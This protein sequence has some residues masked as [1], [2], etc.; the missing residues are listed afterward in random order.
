MITFVIFEV[1]PLST[2]SIKVL[3]LL[4]L[5]LPPNLFISILLAYRLS[6][7]TILV[8][9]LFSEAICAGL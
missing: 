5:N 1:I 2:R 4:Y 9:K 3:I 7:A 8:L 6:D